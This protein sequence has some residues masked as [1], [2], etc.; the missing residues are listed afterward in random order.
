[1]DAHATW[2]SLGFI[3][4][5]NHKNNS[6]TKSLSVTQSPLPTQA[7]LCL[8]GKRGGALML[9]LLATKAERNCFSQLPTAPPFSST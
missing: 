1:M 3:K 2:L 4:L 9:L 5:E 8:D 6:L 7:T